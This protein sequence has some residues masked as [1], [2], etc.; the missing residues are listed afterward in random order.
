MRK[1]GFKSSLAVATNSQEEADEAV[2]GSKTLIRPNIIKYANL[3]ML[4]VKPE[5]Q[6]VGAPS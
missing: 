1:G 3:D 4:A 2:G 6:N 5:A